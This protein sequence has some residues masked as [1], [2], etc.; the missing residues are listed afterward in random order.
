[1]GKVFYLYLFFCLTD[2]PGVPISRPTIVDMEPDSVRVSWQK[3]DIPSFSAKDEPL[4]YL[5]EMQ[6]PPKRDWR[7]IARD[8]PDANYTVRGLTPGQDYRFRVKARTMGGAY[9]EPS[10][11]T[12]LYRTLGNF[13][14]LI[15]KLLSF[16]VD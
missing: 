12:S 4:L 1:M 14:L 8:I 11:S 13:C 7:Q 5:L 6:E 9:G 2:F 15:L 10:P 16:Y 3:V